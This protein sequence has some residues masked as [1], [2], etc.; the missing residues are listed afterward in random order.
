MP[1]GFYFRRQQPS[2]E[3]QLGGKGRQSSLAAS[4]WLTWKELELETKVIHEFSSG[5]EYRVGTRKLPVDGFVPAKNLVL[6]FQGEPKILCVTPSH[7][8]EQWSAERAMTGIKAPPYRRPR[9]GVV[10]FSDRWKNC[11]KVVSFLY[12]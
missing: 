9:C 3:L 4:R 8:S 12:V 2:F 6:E 10:R 11:S 5:Y 1:V 7:P